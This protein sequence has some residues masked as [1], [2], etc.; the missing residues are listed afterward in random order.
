MHDTKGSFQQY[1]WYIFCDLFISAV[2]ERPIDRT[3]DGD[4][5]TKKRKRVE[6]TPDI[7]I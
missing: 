2:T 5:A 7:G 1:D 6:R 4:V 3:E